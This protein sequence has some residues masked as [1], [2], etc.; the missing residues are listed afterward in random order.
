MNES[1]DKPPPK[2]ER[3]PPVATGSPLAPRGRSADET[4]AYTFVEKTV[5]ESGEEAFEENVRSL[6]QITIGSKLG[7]YLLVRKLGQGGMGAVYEARHTKLD[8]TFAL[9]VLPPGFASNAAALSRF[10]QE[11]KAVGKLDHPHIIKATNA[12]EWNGTH[13]LVMEYLDGSDLSVLVK[14]R[15]VLG[16]RDACKVIR[17]AAQGLQHA[18]EHG[19]VHRDIKPSN[20]FITTSGQ[21]KL[22]DLGLARLGGDGNDGGGLTASGQLFGTPDYMAPEQ[23]DD[24]RSVD[25]RAD[26]YSLGCTLGYLLTGKA[27]FDRGLHR[28]HLQIMKQHSETAPPDLTTLRHS[29]PA[30]LNVLFQ[31]LLAKKPED[32]FASAAELITALEPFTRRT[33][34]SRDEATATDVRT[35]TASFSKSSSSVT[36]VMPAPPAKPPKRKIG[37]LLGGLAALILFGV[38]I[39]KITSKDGTVTEIKVPEGS[40]IEITQT[41][42]PPPTRPQPP[43]F[44]PLFNGQD[45]TGWSVANGGVGNWR[46]VD[47]ALTCGGVTDYLYSQ[48]DDYENFHLRAECRINATGNSGLYFR[49]A[50]PVVGIGDYEAQITFRPEQQRLGSLYGLAQPS[51]VTATPDAWL[52]LEI[53]AQA[54]E[55]RVLVNGEQTALYSE[56]RS[57]R[58]LK[59]HLVLQH[60]DNQTLVQFRKIEIKEFPSATSTPAP[61]TL[62][63]GKPLPPLPPLNLDESDPLPKWE[64]PA[65]APPPVVAPCEPQQATDRQKLWADYLK[66]PVIEESARKELGLTFALVPPGE[67]RKVFT[68][69]D[70]PAIEPDMPVR[71]FRIAKPFAMSTTEVTWDQFRQFVEATG[72]KTDAETS[73]VGGVGLNSQHDPKINWRNPPWKPDPNEA[74]TQ[75]TH[76]DAAAFCVWLT[77]SARSDRIHTVDGKPTPDG[78][79]PSAAKRPDKSGHY[80]HYRLPNEAEWLHA[81]R[82]GSVHKHVFGPLPQD[83]ADYAWTIELQDPSGRAGLV[84]P[85]GTKKPNAFGLHDMLGNVCEHVQGALLPELMHPLAFNDSNAYGARVI[86][87]QGWGSTRASAHPDWGHFDYSSFKPTVY[88]GFRV[89][90]EINPTHATGPLDQPLLVRR[91]D[92]LWAR[93]LVSRPESIPGLRSW[94]VELAGIHTYYRNSSIAVNPQGDVIAVGNGHGRISLWNGQGHFQRI[95]SGCNGHIRSLDFSPD[96]HWLAACDHVMQDRSTAR[97]WNV[98]TGALVSVIPI[99]SSVSRRVKFSPDSKQLAISYNSAPGWMIVDLMTGTTRS[100]FTDNFGAGMAWSPSGGELACLH[101]THLRVWDTQ[102]LRLLRE[103]DMANTESLEWSPNGRWLAMRMASGDLVIR[104][105]QTLAVQHTVPSVKVVADSAQGLAWLPDSQRLLVAQDGT[106]PS[107]VVDAIAGKVLVRF[108][109]DFRPHHERERAIASFASGREAVVAYD[110]RLHFFDTT[111]GKKLREGPERANYRHDD[112]HAALSAD[113]CEVFQTGPVG[114]V[115]VSDAQTGAHLRQMQMPFFAGVSGSLYWLFPSP[116]AKSLAVMMNYPAPAMAIVDPQT[117]L[118]RHELSHGPSKVMHTAWSADGKW[119]ATGATDKCV[120]LWNTV[121][122]RL[123]HQLA[124]HPGSIGAIAWAPHGTRLATL[125]EDKQVRLW[126][127]ATGKLVA[128]HKLREPFSV[129]RGGPEVRLAWTADS[130]RLWVG[131]S[132]QIAL[133]DIETGLLGPDEKFGYESYFLNTS[134]D[135]Q[136]LLVREFMGSTFVRG[137]DAQDRRLL[138]QYLGRSAQWHPDNRRFLGHD[139]HY[140]LVGFDVDTNRRL[141]ILLPWLTSGHRL[142]IGP[143]GH[144]QV[145]AG[146]EEHIVYVALHDDG[147]QHTYSPAE[148]ATK[149]GWKN[150]PE[151]AMLLGK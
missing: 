136:R 75:V 119:L 95:L 96:G 139:G 7:P 54:S 71:R 74:V 132:G 106:E 118:L 28:S 13:Y 131:L 42:E 124:E 38:I 52:T 128:T 27:P 148:F 102:T 48:R 142:C 103:V 87:G 3:F 32:R 26:L 150:N 135:G 1:D 45:L 34:A 40:K 149:F 55:L 117:G 92:P 105:A 109:Q 44:V 33:E 63:S 4:D 47:G 77:E 134:P 15:G 14:D 49:A 137:H 70:D 64:L 6:T 31:R 127:P 20:L 126:D 17:Q 93:A 141:G 107:C 24:P 10:G 25:A 35:P 120:R 97:V 18:H 65:G 73:G 8:K 56:K 66:R 114:H 130:R 94:S 22:L 57:D 69:P 145:N 80:E 62:A 91:G 2:L 111:T 146:I 9:K 82:A 101:R 30:E 122:G 85:V 12:D 110:S 143:T 29:V 78:K 37:L 84:R 108:D 138:G 99:F 112:L 11:M 115:V 51:S 79:Q 123:E 121:T 113:G 53:I 116:D 104:D 83:I 88:T 50:K 125:A 68:R 89:L 100:P 46:V 129:F 98:E 90:Q 41:N 21:V 5:T 36:E 76:R 86:K 58:R 140:G 23:W 144:Y 81:C 72:Y 151:K 43:E 19:L 39:I 61:S 60:H 59:G 147:S 133:L 16:V 67:F